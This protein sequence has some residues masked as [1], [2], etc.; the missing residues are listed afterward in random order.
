MN[1]LSPL[2]TDNPNCA[3]YA[4]IYTSYLFDILNDI[5]CI[6]IEKAVE[7]LEK[8][9]ANDNTVFLIGNGGSAATCSH[10][11]EDLAYGMVAS[12][13]KPVRALSLTD[14]AP[15]IT[16]LGNDEG[17]ENAFVGQLRS[18]YKPG[19]VLFAISGSGNSLNLIKAVEYA[20]KVDVMTIG[21]LGF[22]GGMLKGLCQHC[23]LVKSPRGAYAPV[24]DIHLV[25]TH[26]IATYFMFGPDGRV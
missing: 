20:N 9:R 12:G 24:E 26:I 4:K 25:I 15:Y 6:E 17:Y 14:N 13:K 23:I 5:D 22:D 10:F 3:E 7:I 18:L 21:L 19:D 8:A 2:F 11:C 1:D 16:A